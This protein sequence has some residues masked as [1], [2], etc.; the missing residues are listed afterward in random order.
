MKTIKWFRIFSMHWDFCFITFTLLITF[1]MAHS[2]DC[3]DWPTVSLTNQS[4]VD[5]FAITWPN[6][7][8]LDG[9][10]MIGGTWN[11]GSDITDLTALSKL[12]YVNGDL[13][14]RYNHMLDG[15]NG[16]GNLLSIGGDLQITLCVSLTDLNGISGLKSIGGSV[17]ISSNHELENAGGIENIGNISG[18]LIFQDNVSLSALPEFKNLISIAGSLLIK[19]N[20][21]LSN[22]F[23]LD[24]LISVSGDIVLHGNQQLDSLFSSLKLSQLGGN[25][26]ISENHLMNMTGLDS[27]KSI[28]GNVDI[29]SEHYLQTLAGMD[30][31]HMIGGYLFIGY[32][33]SLQ[34]LQHLSR[35]KSIGGHLNIDSNDNLQSIGGLFNLSEIN[36]YLNVS[37]NPELI[38]LEG[39]QNIDPGSIR[40][41]EG[42]SID[43]LTIFY[44][45]NLSFC[46]IK[47]ICDFLEMENVTYTVFFNDLGCNTSEEIFDNCHPL[48]QCSQLIYPQPNDLQVSINSVIK[49]DLNT[50]ATGYFLGIGTTESLYDLMILSDV[51]N[52]NEYQPDTFPCGEQIFVHIIPYNDNGMAESCDKYSFN[53]EYVE[54]GILGDSLLCFGDT[55]ELSAV[56]G[57]FWKWEPIDL[58]EDPTKK[59][60]KFFPQETTSIKL[61][62][63]T[64]NGCSD[65][66]TMLINVQKIEIDIDSIIHFKGEHGG[67]IYTSISEDSAHKIFLWSGPDGYKAYKKDIDGLEPGVYYLFVTDTLTG[68]NADTSI[69]IQDLTDIADISDQGIQFKIYPNP[70]NSEL[71]LEKEFTSGY[72]LLVEIYDMFGRKYLEKLWKSDNAYIVID[73]SS[74]P[75]GIYNIHVYGSEGVFKNKLLVLR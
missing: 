51:G 15:L 50:Q 46:A 37:F 36:G 3:P 25:L 31:L 7:T 49:W 6:C 53:T 13:I 52:V 54:A 68:C 43:D 69:F 39:L 30:S 66:S 55:L 24:S 10:L 64:G 65:T 58:F 4:A 26:N 20:N 73:V 67:S 72:D 45:P 57:A 18:D 70:A 47:S 23:G 17:A 74:F 19:R 8:G 48:P 56:D 38:S 71:I 60:S 21:I 16:L 1:N 5:A 59:T 9:N 44:N 63:F 2:Q 22:L 12:K 32:N 11:N 28:G 27:L 34:N 41:E 75:N 61:I 62:A 33:D 35:L 29:S 40:A 42:S 14:V